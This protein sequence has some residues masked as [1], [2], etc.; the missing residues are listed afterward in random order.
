MLGDMKI[1]HVRLTRKD[2]KAIQAL[3]HS[4]SHP[5]RVL[6]RANILLKADSGMKDSDIGHHLDCTTVH[7]AN[8]RQRYCTQGLQRALYDAPRSG[9][10]AIFTGKDEAK[11][12]ALACSQSPDGASRWTLKLLAEEAVKQKI[13]SDISP[14]TVW[15]MLERQ[16]TKPWLK[17]N[18]VRSKTH[19]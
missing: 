10:P 8:I 18:V 15:L 13:V 5:A 17:K 12:V 6:K 7:V 14:Q 9:K 3:F 19:V 16:N 11:I 1:H 2:R 4:G